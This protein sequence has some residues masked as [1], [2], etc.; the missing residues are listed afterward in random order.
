MR[1][2]IRKT[3]YRPEIDGLRALAVIPVILIHS[4]VEAFSGGFLGVDIF[5]VISG[6]LITSIIWR[7]V[8]CGTFS[9]AEFYRRR[10]RRILP[11]LIVLIGIV[12]VLSFWVMLPEQF[13]SYSLSVLSALGFAANIYF[14]FNLDYFSPD[15]S[16]IPM[17]HLWSLGVEE[18]FYVFFPL[19]L[20]LFKDRSRRQLIITLSIC[21]ISSLL[22]AEIGSR[23]TSQFSFYLLPTRAWELMAGALLALCMPEIKLLHGRTNRVLIELFSLCGLFLIVFS[24][25]IMDEEV[26]TPSVFLLPVILGSVLVIGFSNQG[27]FTGKLLASKPFRVVGLMSYSAY[28]W[29]QPVIALVKIQTFIVTDRLIE[30]GITLSLTSLAAWLSWKF[31][32]RPFRSPSPKVHTLTY[33]SMAITVTFITIGFSLFFVMSNPKILPTYNRALSVVGAEI[34]NQVFENDL[35]KACVIRDSDIRACKLGVKA[36]ESSKPAI[37]LWGDSYAGALYRGLDSE[38]KQAGLT[39]I[40]YF[41]PGCPPITGLSRPSSA[42]CKENIHNEIFEKI[43][44]TPGPATVILHGNILGAINNRDVFIE[45]NPSN[46]ALVSEQL[47]KTKKLLNSGGKKLAIVEQGPK[48]P[49]NVTHFYFKTRMAGLNNELSL[50]TK[51]FLDENRPLE[52]IAPIPDMYISTVE[53][54]CDEIICKTFDSNAGLLFTDKDHV[55]LSQSKLL[56]KYIL[57]KF[58]NGYVDSI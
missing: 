21:S 14:G 42:T 37:I 33:S 50:P 5:F 56:A 16:E 4:G 48:F 25:F 36:T 46:V 18:Q 31:V 26:R 7:E 12:T 51:M 30:I 13:R 47:L 10:A 11:A 19:L 35:K 40:V 39:G 1:S 32:E 9:I 15:S 6:F 54:F 38:M 23:V 22:L 2:E 41:R 8:E 17:L 52:A 34:A 44:K 3:S 43:L 28:L 49:K 45:G 27:N 53:F 57:S 24:L 55:S 20:L 58:N 29:H